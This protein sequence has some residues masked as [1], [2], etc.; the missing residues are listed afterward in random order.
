MKPFN[1][2]IFDLD[3]TLVTIEG[4]DW[5]AKRKGVEKEVVK[6]TEQSMN[7]LLPV[8]IAFEK[9]MAMIAPTHADLVKLGEKYCDSLVPG[10][11]KTITVLHSLG[12]DI[13][14]VTGNFDPAPQIVADRLGIPK[15]RVKNNTVLFDKKNNYTGFDTYNPLI[16]NGGKA[17][18]V[19]KY[20]KTNGQRTAFIG[21]AV[22]DLETKQVVDLFI[23]FGGVVARNIVKEQSE[24]FVDSPNMYA[25]LGDLLTEQEKQVIQYTKHV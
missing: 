23:G 13:W 21:D 12:K 9:K 19:K 17:A 20:V 4:L 5:L 10:A 8:Q 24:V 6:I 3:S 15:H 7:G 18:T 22:T 25:I 16:K 1:T 2:I 14:I 11:K